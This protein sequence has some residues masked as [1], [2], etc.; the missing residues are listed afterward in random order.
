MSEIS[1]PTGLE[2]L[3]FK[4]EHEWMCMLVG[5]NYT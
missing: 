5:V 4:Y 1:K 3:H 2:K